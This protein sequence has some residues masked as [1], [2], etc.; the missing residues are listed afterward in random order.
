MKR[1]IVFIFLS[2]M[3]P[4]VAMAAEFTVVALPDTQKYSDNYP[5]IYVEQTRWVVDNADEMKIR[6]VTHLGDIVDEGSDLLQWDNAYAAMKLLHSINMAYGTCVGNHD[7]R[8]PGSYYDPD[9]LN[10]LNSFD[11][12]F[13]ADKEWFG[14]ASP[15]GL[16]NYQIIN[17]DGQDFLF[18]HLLVETPARE[19]AWA[20]TIL[21]EH[22]DKPAWVST[23]R[24]MYDWSFI[25]AG[26]C[27]QLSYTFS[28]SYRHDG[29]AANDFFDHFISANRQIFLVHCGHNYA[30]YDQ[31]STNQ[32]GLDVFELLADYQA[33]PNG[34]NGWLRYYNF[35]TEQNRIDAVTYSPALEKF[36]TDKDSQFSINV[37]FDRYKQSLPFIVFQQGVSGYEGMTDTWINQNAPEINYSAD[38]IVRVDNDTVNS[39]TGDYEG[40]GLFKFED[41]FQ[42]PIMESDPAPTRIPY[43]A[44]IKS[45]TM[46]LTLE[47]DVFVCAPDFYVYRIT[48]DW[49]ESATWQSLENGISVGSETESATLAVFPG[50]N[51]DTGY[52]RTFDITPAVQA[53]SDGEP[54]YGL[55]I[56]SENV[57]NCDDGIYIYSSIYDVS[58]VRPSLSVEFTYTAINEPPEVET[59]LSADKV[60]IYEGGEVDLSVAAS[61]P[62]A[63][64]PLVFRIGGEDVGYATGKGAISHIVLFEDEG[65]YHFNAEVADDQTVV[66]AGSLTINVSNLP[67]RIVSMTR[68]KTVDI[69]RRFSFEAQAIDPGAVDRITANW[70]LN[71]DGQYDDFEGFSG[72]LFFS[73]AGDYTLCVRVK[74]DDG[75]YSSGK[76]VIHV[77]DVPADGD[78]DS[79]GLSIDTNNHVFS[80]SDD[81][82]AFS[83]CASGPGVSPQPPSPFTAENCIS[84]FDADQDA[85]VDMDDK[86][87]LLGL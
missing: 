83:F 33:D 25:G 84:A 79:D 10:Y 77:R 42:E 68:E 47:D 78:F 17:T 62:G 15:S 82:A 54:N 19:L 4:C 70:D 29:I 71:Q 14:D 40:Q 57:K 51:Q 7:I 36:R 74:D 22:K 6:F 46:T 24:Y 48:R 43:G 11:P 20:Q 44:T 87:L 38:A 28:P 66:Q 1:L 13:Y 64:D 18:M 34:G 61:D 60:T 39:I 35:D 23:H 76:A 58:A 53:W 80:D 72:D 37:E 5:S 75:G 26:R 52:G 85:D 2:F 67:P 32:Y 31:V 8:Y 41:I 56:V 12:S 65:S 3:L 16:S 30:E 73:Q 49:C 55:L 86:N 45:A 27:D 63:S 21:N 50:K 9:G 59:L 81:E 69:G